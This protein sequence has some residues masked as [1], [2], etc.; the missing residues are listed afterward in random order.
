MIDSELK[1]IL[2][3]A[4][5]H[6]LKTCPFKTKIAYINVYAKEKRLIQNGYELSLGLGAGWSFAYTDEELDWFEYYFHRVK[7]KYMN[8]YYGSP[9][10]YAS[11]FMESGAVFNKAALANQMN[12]SAYLEEKGII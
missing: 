5:D 7:K 4:R 2:E 6:I 12:N 1:K 9:C 8:L 11:G 10:G 3:G